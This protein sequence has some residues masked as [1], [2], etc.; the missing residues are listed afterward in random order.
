MPLNLPE[1][2]QYRHLVRQLARR[3]LRVKYANT[4]IGVLWAV[5]QPL[6]TMVFFGVFFGR[7]AKLPSDGLP[8]PVFYFSGLLPWLYVSH[9]VSNATTVLNDH[10][11]LIGRLYFPRLVM[12]IASVL[13]GLVDFAI[14]FVFL[15]GMMAWYG[16]WPGVW[17]PAVAGFLGL[18]VL[19]AAALGIWLS[20][21]NARYRDVRY[22]LAFALQFW[23][24]ASPV[25]YPMTLVPERWRSLYALNPVAVVIQGFRWALTG[26]GFPGLTPILV[27]VGAVAVLAVTGL[28]YFRRTELDMADRL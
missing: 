28:F 14:A 19:T 22:G 12:P 26:H 9:V 1:L 2:W 15:L 8:Y 3:D 4:V 6:A 25:V 23:L 24:L 18:G 13:G 21:L 27:S 16:L 5:V 7:L 10:A 20:A 11:H 17:V